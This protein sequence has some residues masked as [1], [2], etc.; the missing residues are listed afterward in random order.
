MKYILL[1]LF[2]VEIVLFHFCSKCSQAISGNVFEKKR[3]F[4]NKKERKMK[5]NH[6]QI[7]ETIFEK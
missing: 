1:R 3:A 2:F 6:L 7:K 4:L 5:R